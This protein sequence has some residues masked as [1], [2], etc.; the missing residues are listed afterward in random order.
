[1]RT[2]AFYAVI[3][4][5]ACLTSGCGWKM[6]ERPIRVEGQVL[7]AGTDAPVEGAYI[8]IADDREKLDFAITSDTLTDSEG[9]FDATFRYLHEKWMWVGIPVFWF[10]DMP[11]RLYVEATKSGYRGRIAEIDCR[12]SG[13]AGKDAAPSFRLEPIRIRK[14]LPRGRASR[15]SQPGEER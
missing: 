14:E 8:D 5:S 15:R 7:E 4:V 1:M 2:I 12:A 13:T 9:K 10:P 6:I 3:T 11:E